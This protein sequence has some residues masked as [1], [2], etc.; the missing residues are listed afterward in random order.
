MNILL[1]TDGIYPF[2]MGGMQRHS[3]MLMKYFLKNNHRISLVH[4]VPPSYQ[5]P[6]LNDLSEL[7]G[8]PLQNLSITEIPFPAPGKLPGH[9][10]R[11]NKLYS[12]RI[13]E[14]IQDRLIAFDAIYAQGF[15]GYAFGKNKLPI[16]LFVN[17]HGYEMFQP[18]AGLKAKAEAVLL[19]RIAREVSR[20]ADFV[21][22]FGYIFS[23]ILRKL[24]VP[25][26]R[27]LICAHGVESGWLTDATQKKIN[28]VR[29]FV[30][31]GRYERRKGIEELHQAIQ[32]LNKEQQQKAIF[33]FIGPIPEKVRLKLSNCIYHGSVSPASKLMDLLDRMD[34]LLCPSH[35]EGLPTVIMEGM[36]RGLAIIAT[37]VGAV[38]QLIRNNGCLINDA[39]PSLIA[40]A[41]AKAITL[42]EHE[43]AILQK[44]SISIIR[45]NYT[46]DAVI[47][48]KEELINKG[49]N[50]W[51]GL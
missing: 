28:S 19:R 6:P 26:E 43:I 48:K 49:I 9:Y 50:D 15:T 22:S 27:E 47:K 45:E 32:S 41:I 29:N 4:C 23:E 3:F 2:V 25:Q 42:T 38:E 14:F 39:K 30:F 7:Q 20:S 37:Q 40:E 51:K 1:L 36:A 11:E 12:Q 24:G 35:S 46:W 21:F 5:G 33:H 18:A 16:P 8:I 44:N 13:Y 10:V 34:V 17:L 31:V